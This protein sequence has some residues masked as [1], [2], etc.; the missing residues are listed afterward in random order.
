MK[1]YLRFN[2]LLYK[3]CRIKLILFFIITLN[4]CEVKNLFNEPKILP[5]FTIINLKEAIDLERS[6]EKFYEACLQLAYMERNDRLIHIFDTYILAD[7]QHISF[8]RYVLSKIS[9]EPFTESFNELPFRSMA[10]NIKFANELEISISA[11]YN[12][13]IRMAQ[14]ENCGIAKTAFMWAYNTEIK[15]ITDY[16]ILLESTYSDKLFKPND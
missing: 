15:R 16:K 13:G 10:E 3:F 4:S 2:S 9:K 1:T 5:S 12:D 7:K 6:T 8:F 14:K 11:K